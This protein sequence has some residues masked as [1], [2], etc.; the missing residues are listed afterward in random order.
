MSRA[1]AGH[2][3]SIGIAG[4]LSFVFASMLNEGY[5]WRGAYF[6][7]GLATLV[8]WVIVFGGVP[9]LTTE[10]KTTGAAPVF[11]FRPVLRNRSA[12]AYALA[13]CAHTWEMNS[14]RGWAVAFLTFVATTT[15]ERGHWLA[16]T[17]VAMTMGLIGTGASVA[18]NEASIRVGRQR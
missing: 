7:A 1:V 16:P 11:D 17:I 4:S 14:L 2:A 12:M 8:A 13:Y 18:G 10:P 3:A 15:G 9:S 5:G 6:G